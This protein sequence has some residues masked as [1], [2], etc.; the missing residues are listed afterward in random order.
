MEDSMKNKRTKS[1]GERLYVGER[2]ISANLFVA[3]SQGWAR[4]SRLLTSDELAQRVPVSLP[5]L[6]DRNGGDDE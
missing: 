5:S 2:E 3:Q 4:K 6:F 1:T